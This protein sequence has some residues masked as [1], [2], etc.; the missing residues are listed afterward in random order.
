MK[1]EKKGLFI[2]LGIL[3]VSILVAF[4][5]IGNSSYGG[6]GQA[7]G[8]SGFGES[9]AVL[10]VQGV[11]SG[12]DG[13]SYN[14]NWLLQS[15]NEI[16]NDS[17]NQGILLYINSPG[18]GVYE[19]DEVYLE[20]KAYQEYTGNP[21]YVSMGSMAASGGYYLAT[22][23]DSIYANRNTL[24]GSIGIIMGSSIDL[25]GLMERYGIKSTT[26]TAGANKNM[27]NF[28]APVT[29]EQKA[30]MQSIADESYEQFVGIVA[31]ERGLTLPETRVLADGRIYTAKQALAN[32][33]IDGIAT[34]E[35]TQ[36]I[37]EEDLGLD[38]PTYWYYSY[39]PD[40][41]FWDVLLMKAGGNSSQSAEL[42][43]I[44]KALL[45]V[46]KG[47]AYYCNW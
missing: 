22:A 5:A 11:I 9:I 47:P 4:S 8:G 6:Y 23:A 2:F 3:T 7:I 17:T 19:T 31:Q 24:T 29:P 14:Q 39:E 40:L 32:G 33:L 42:E 41:S 45:P 13:V 28:D 12:D 36:W 27:F 16:A 26:I 15:I 43:I 21:I 10:E 25:T 20:L 30:I 38:D 46:A 18:G 37:M 1:S 34:F 35:E 44:K